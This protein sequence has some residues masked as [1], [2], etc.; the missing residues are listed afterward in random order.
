V[1]FD[2]LAVNELFDDHPIPIGCDRTGTRYRS[3]VASVADMAALLR[4]AD[5][6]PPDATLDDYAR[7]RGLS[8]RGDSN[9]IG[10]MAVLAGRKGHQ[11]NV[12]RGRLPGG[13][14]GLL[15]HRFVKEWGTNRSGRA[16]D[17]YVPYT[18]AAIAVPQMTGT[19]LRFQVA[20]DGEP[21]VAAD[22]FWVPFDAGQPGWR[23]FAAPATDV[24]TLDAVL[25]STPFADAPRGFQL[26]FGTGVLFARQPGFLEADHELD[27][28][29]G[30]TSHLA[31]DL[32]ERADQLE[33]EPFEVPLPAPAPDLRAARRARRARPEDVMYPGLDVA[34]GPDLRRRLKLATSDLAM[35]PEDTLAFHRAFPQLAVPGHAFAVW[36]GTLPGTEAAGRLAAYVETGA[37]ADTPF[38]V[39]AAVLEVEPDAETVSEIVGDAQLTVAD[40]LLSLQRVRDGELD[41]APLIALGREAF[42]LSRRAE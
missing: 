28:L 24:A 20:R 5:L 27:W 22:A 35:T 18:Y 23:V 42:E 38:G 1:S 19:L 40:G 10:F 32:H 7:A 25:A 12:L 15:F 31:A 16:A 14:D 9:V 6:E 21:H 3:W 4:R 8:H 36:R 29:A 33:R 30:T 11:F 17:V 39:N 41:A 13:E 2:E 34:P 26:G 37:R